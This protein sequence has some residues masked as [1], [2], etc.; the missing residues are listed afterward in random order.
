MRMRGNIRYQ[1]IVISKFVYPAFVGGLYAQMPKIFKHVPRGKEE[2]GCASK[3]DFET[4]SR[5]KNIGCLCDQIGK[6]VW[7]DCFIKYRVLLMEKKE[8]STLFEKRSRVSLLV[9]I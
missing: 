2:N 3:R 8:I 6:R 1:K 4:K 5:K 7:V 9:N